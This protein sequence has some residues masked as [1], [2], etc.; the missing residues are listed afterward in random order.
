M[1]YLGVFKMGPL[2]ALCMS[3]VAL[4]L[5]GV[6]SIGWELALLPGVLQGVVNFVKGYLVNKQIQK[7]IDQMQEELENRKEK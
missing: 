3:L 6:S 5:G 7:H 1:T 4:K 2:T